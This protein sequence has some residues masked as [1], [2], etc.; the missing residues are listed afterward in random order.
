MLVYGKD[1][2]RNYVRSFES[3]MRYVFLKVGSNWKKEQV[4]VV[5]IGIVLLD[6]YC[7]R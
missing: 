6:E 7:R 1:I 4:Y 3:K 5:K 2:F